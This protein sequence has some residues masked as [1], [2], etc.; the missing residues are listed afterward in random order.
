M[1]EILKAIEELKKQIAAATTAS[2]EELAGMQ[3]KLTKLGEDLV[4]AQKAVE[5]AQAEA[6]AAKT[7]AEKLEAEALREPDPVKHKGIM[8]AIAA[9]QAPGRIQRTQNNGAY[10]LHNIFRAKMNN[11]FS[12]C[13]EEMEVSR[14]LEALGYHLETGGI[15]VPFYLPAIPD[16]HKAFREELA[17]KMA[18]DVDP[19]EIVWFLKQFPELA[20][21]FGFRRKADLEIGDDSLGGL[22]VPV[23]QAPRILDFLRSRSVLI[24]AGAQEV[25]LPPTGNITYPRLLSDPTFTYTDPDTTTDATASAFNFGPVRLIAKSLRGYVTIP[26]DLVRYSTP[27]VEVIVRSSLGSKA[28]VAEDNQFLEGTG[29]SIAPKGLLTY[30]LSAV[31][32][33]TAGS[34]TLHACSTGNDG[35]TIRPEDPALIQGLY[36]TSDDPDP[37]TGWI[38]RPMLWACLVNRRTD[39]VAAGDA[40]GPFAFWTSRGDIT[41]GVNKTLQGVP[42]HTTTNL[43]NND[44]K[45][46]SGATLHRLVYGNFRRMLIGRAGALE[47][48]ASEHIRFLQD[49][50]V[51]KAILRSD[52][53]LEHEQSFVVTRNL[54]Q[55]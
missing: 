39:A 31:E 40:A 35:D 46:A 2:K 45:G 50:T 7:K 19:G 41:A 21:D 32:T 5:A 12:L 26:N 13:K 14:K 24:A 6:T 54:R 10:R 34:V 42:V 30:A 49:K 55:V 27:A 51:I 4:A 16:E 1:D 38:M 3:A 20:Q 37:A 48:A 8:A 43:S 33:P 17:Q 11:D 18:L 44:T 9:G 52:M 15:L 36:E 28:A 29:S 22:L 25:P 53:G 23:T 47:L